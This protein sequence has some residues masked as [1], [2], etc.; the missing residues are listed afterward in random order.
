MHYTKYLLLGLFISSNLSVAVQAQIV[1]DGTTNTNVTTTDSGITINEGDRA[2]NN[3][4]HSFSEF[5]V[6][7]GSSATFNNALDVENIFS[8]V[9]GGNVSNINGA[10]NANGGANLLLINPAG[11]V[12]GENAS[13]NIGG[14][15]SATTADSLL[16]ESGEFSAVNPQA[17]PLLTIN[18]PI[19]LNFGDNAGEIIN[20]ANSGQSRE[21]KFEK[22]DRVEDVT[23]NNPVGLEVDAGE[24]ITLVGGDISIDGGGVTAP[25]GR[26]ELGGLSAA[27]EVTIDA[28]G[29]GF[30]NGVAKANLSLTNDA[31]A[32][33]SA[34]GRGA[35]AVN[36]NNLVLSE[37]SEL[38]AGIAEGAESNNIQTGDI[39]I[40]ADESVRLIGNALDIEGLDTVISNHVGLSPIKRD[41]SELNSNSSA[42]GNGGSIFI[43]T[44]R[45]E[46]TDRATI[47]TITFGEGNAG[48]VRVT[49]ND[50]KLSGFAEITSRVRIGARGN[51]GN[52]EVDVGSLNFNDGF[53]VSDIGNFAEEEDTRLAVGNSGNVIVNARDAII[54]TTSEGLSIILSQV[55]ENG[56]GNAGS[57]D[58]NTKVLS[59][60]KGSMI[61]ATNDGEGDAGSIDINATQLLEL[62]GNGSLI[63]SQLF[64]NGV[65]NGGDINIT[66]PTVFLADFSKI[67][68]SALKGSV[69]EAGNVTVN[70][71][72]N[73]RLTQGSVIDTLS[74]SD[75]D[76]GNINLNTNNLELS[77]GGKIVTANE[78]GGN[79][80][81]VDL[82]IEGDIVFD[83]GNPPTENN[84]FPEQILI[85][86]VLETGIFANNPI[87]STGS[88]GSIFVSANSV[89][90]RDR[91]SI[92]ASTF[93][94][95]GGNIDLQ[96]ADALSL[97]NNSIISADAGGVGSG[98]NV[99]IDTDLVIA[100]G[101]GGNGSDIIANAAA[102]GAG[103]NIDI[104]TDAIL[105][106]QARK[107]TPFNNTN[108][109]DAS[110]Q[111][112]LDG[113]ITI[114]DPDVDPTSG[115]VEL[116]SVPIDANA[117]L[118]QD[119]CR[120]ENENI[121]GGSSFIVTGRGGLTPTSADSLGNINGVVN[122]TDEADIEVSSDG[123]IAV[124]RSP[125]KTPN[126]SR[127]VVQSQG[128]AVAPDGSL[129]LTA[130]TGNT[131]LQNSPNHPDCQI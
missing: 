52:V 32:D 12:F 70:A 56:R 54:M 67:A 126:K 104:S 13:L 50:V 95:S 79:A 16:F 44:D 38:F 14:S 80:G 88:G 21:V 68:A 29:I 109:I 53:I 63:L 22:G 87:T 46:L 111:F 2:G 97:R 75:F 96:I 62:T 89:E 81:N 9:T 116:P 19:G 86:L 113:T 93:S 30:P 1:K 37:G 98:G 33:V 55:Q 110:S 43:D 84:I 17:A 41:N 23:V 48:S 90:F 8:R 27:G 106:L 108:D 25:G 35:I 123:V 103:G 77:T 130:N 131:S 10:I 121:A 83:N 122:W 92:S 91:G 78:Q 114:N 105:G 34:D 127:S 94:G 66:A 59:L 58:I 3:L 45:L 64:D 107:A 72:D 60:G 31:Q 120:V 74:E 115:I 36:V 71:E 125:D 129:W 112:G 4:F 124:K 65:G 119:L 7:D 39:T 20:R 69:G 85:D 49:A 61:L 5:S 18:R 76:S 28:D 11:I 26:I 42:I 57:I 24:N 47:S 51:S 73:I 100:F 15:F 101:N 99:N 40:D 102:E 82:N 118:A 117:I 6:P 128:F